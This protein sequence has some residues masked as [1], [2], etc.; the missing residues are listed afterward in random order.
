MVLDDTE[1][2]RSLVA[3]VSFDKN[4]K[5][6]DLNNQVAVEKKK[7]NILCIKKKVLPSNSD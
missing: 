5:E 3:P 4:M 1:L 7:S 2:C 6:P